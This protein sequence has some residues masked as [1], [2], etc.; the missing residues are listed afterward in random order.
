MV[1]TVSI[2]C[3][4]D[5]LIFIGFNTQ[6]KITFFMALSKIERA[7]SLERGVV[8]SCSSARSIFLHRFLTPR[9][10]AWVGVSPSFRGLHP[11]C[12]NRTALQGS[13]WS[14]DMN[15]RHRA[16]LSTL[17]EICCEIFIDCRSEILGGTACKAEEGHPSGLVK[18]STLCF[19][20]NSYNI[21]IIFRDTLCHH[22]GLQAKF[23]DRLVWDGLWLVISQS[24]L[25]KLGF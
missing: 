19:F 6:I 15:I 2:L 23:T 20:N 4:I 17:L 18:A 13:I 5:I 10:T 16:G 11:L 3:H 21:C 24:S 22:G 12:I 14:S 9:P 25:K 7:T 8:S 1:F